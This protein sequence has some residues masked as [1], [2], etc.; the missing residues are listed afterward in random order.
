MGMNDG[1]R[2]FYCYLQVSVGVWVAVRQINGVSV[3]RKGDVERQRVP[4]FF[5][6]AS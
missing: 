2:N 3:V 1:V 4:L 6:V 5:L